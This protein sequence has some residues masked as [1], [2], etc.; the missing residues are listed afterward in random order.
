MSNPEIFDLVGY[1]SQ[2]MTIDKNGN[3]VPE[4]NHE[5]EEETK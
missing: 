1:L 4:K 5:E 2:G 3:V